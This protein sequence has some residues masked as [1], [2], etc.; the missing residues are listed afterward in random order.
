MPAAY[1]TYNYPSYWEGREYEHQSEIIALEAFLEKI[2]S[3]N[4][5][6]DLG[7]GYGRLIPTFKHRAKK[8]Y[9][10]DPS[11]KLLKI[12]RSKHK[13]KHIEYIQSKIENL[14]QKL[15]KK[16]AD[17]IIFIRVAHHI[18]DIDEVLQI[19]KKLSKNNGYFIFEFANKKHIK[20]T[21]CEF[22]KGNL[23]FPL[24]IFPKDLRSKRSKKKKVLPFLNYHPDDIDK[25]LDD[26]GFDIVEKRSISN[27]RNTFLKNSLP[28]E[29][30]L[31]IESFLQK[32][33]AKVCFGPS[34][35]YL[36]HN[37]G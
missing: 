27:I 30:L 6:Y 20:A 7:S 37:R 14:P 32:P 25:K 17:L 15:F 5:I 12:A 2:K 21:F 3:I 18:E 34:M 10:T 22:F 13:D 19:I 16:K 11:A 36:C 1:D 35:F 23:T 4:T 33:L 9:I 29:F 24:E 8:I 28:L 26:L 31:S